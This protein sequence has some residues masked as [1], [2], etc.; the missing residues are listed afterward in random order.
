MI[1][2]IMLIRYADGSSD[3]KTWMTALSNHFQT[4]PK[5]ARGSAFEGASPSF[6]AY[7]LIPCYYNSYK[8]LY[9]NVHFKKHPT[10]LHFTAKP[11]VTAESDLTGA[12]LSHTSN[13]PRLQHD[14]APRI[15]F[16]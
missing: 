3:H 7:Q 9:L 12:R 11:S 15:I 5:F 8:N 1:L 16:P 13:P 4:H 6:S 10:P 2:F 14:T